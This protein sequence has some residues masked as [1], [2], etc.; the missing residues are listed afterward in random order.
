MD[1]QRTDQTEHWLVSGSYYYQSINSNIYL[2]THYTLVL[3][4][5]PK[6]GR[7]EKTGKDPSQMG[8]PVESVATHITSVLKWLYTKYQSFCK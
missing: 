5:V 4:I 7:N 6:M 1:R 8:Y 3:I 2:I